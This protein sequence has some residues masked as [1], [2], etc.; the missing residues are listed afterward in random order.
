MKSKFIQVGNN[1]LFYF[2]PNVKKNIDKTNFYVSINKF[3]F[4]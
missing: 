4:H 3:K 1:Q 2:F